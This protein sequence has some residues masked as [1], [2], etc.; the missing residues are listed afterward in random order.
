M[1]R[2]PS[3]RL[4]ILTVS[5]L[6]PVFFP[7]SRLAGQDKPAAY[8]NI[9]FNKVSPEKT[10]DYLNLEGKIWKP[11]Q[12][13][14]IRLGGLAGWNVFRVWF[15][16][17]GSEYNY[18]VMELYRNYEDMTFVYGDDI[19]TRVHPGI[20]EAKLMED[21]Y[22]AREIVRAQSAERIFLVRPETGTAPSKYV[23][24]TFLDVKKSNE[25]QFE[26]NV[27]DVVVPALRE[28][29]K[30]GFNSGWDLFRLVLPGGDN[31]PYQYISFEYINNMSL[32]I[33]P[34]EPDPSKGLEPAKIYRTELWE[35]LEY[36]GG[37]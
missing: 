11:I 29:M 33:K 16:G 24:V 14:H 23:L 3:A 10:T 21:T 6:L 1:K 32:A 27:S 20:N 8:T 34:G 2:I 5:F 22:R 7:V 13:E 31:V 36:L 26:K 9:D 28:R 19:I 12:Q 17:T 15:S 37:Y 30:S 25:A 18:A 35:R 4:I